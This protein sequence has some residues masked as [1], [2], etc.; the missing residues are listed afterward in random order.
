M[1]FLKIELKRCIYMTFNL[2]NS[3]SMLRYLI[4]IYIIILIFIFN[5][6]SNKHEI[7]LYYVINKI[8]NKL[9]NKHYITY[10]N[11]LN[12]KYIRNL[13]IILILIT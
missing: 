8:Y 5:K 12:Y 1:I 2:Y 13:V 4:Y 11:Y 7:T 6:Y 3:I 9:K 10:V